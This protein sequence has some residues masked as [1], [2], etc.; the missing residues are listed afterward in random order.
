MVA[1]MTKRHLK[2]D[3]SSRAMVAVPLRDEKTRGFAMCLR[4]LMAGHS[5]DLLSEGTVVC[6]DDWAS[7]GEEVRSWYGIWG[8]ATS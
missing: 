2:R 7:S 5:F 4:E 6:R 3:V 8:I 1:A